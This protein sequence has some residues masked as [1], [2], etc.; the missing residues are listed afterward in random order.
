MKKVV[1][2][3]GASNGMGLAAA[4]LFASKGWL[5][6]GGARRVEKIPTEDGIH[7]LRL[8]VTDH[9]SNTAF[10]ET[11]IKEAGRIEVLINNAGYGEYSAV[12]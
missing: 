9:Q 11:I 10:I 5:V 12:D 2:I 3:T 6:Y 4:K 7:A 1:V 8:D